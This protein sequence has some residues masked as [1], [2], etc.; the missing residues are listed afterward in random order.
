M[1]CSV[2]SFL[3]GFICKYFILFGPIVSG[4]IFFI[5]FLDRS[6]LIITFAVTNFLSLF[7]SLMSSVSFHETVED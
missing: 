5:S 7:R 1:F 6:F 2:K 4:N 3:V